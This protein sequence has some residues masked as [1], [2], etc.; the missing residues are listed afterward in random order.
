MLKKSLSVPTYLVIASEAKQS[1]PELAE[2]WIASSLTLLAMTFPVYAWLATA[3]PIAACAAARRA[4][5]T[6]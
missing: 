5:G 1:T 2:I 4:I 3:L 6:R